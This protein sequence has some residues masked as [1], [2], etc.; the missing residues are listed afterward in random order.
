MAN[1]RPTEVQRADA[2]RNRA[3]ILEV[4]YQAFTENPN[5]SL[6]SIAK[7]ANIGPGTLY[8]HFPNREALLLAVNKSEID[9]LAEK[10]ERSLEEQEPLDAFRE[11][12]RRSAALIRVKH[13]LGEALSAAAHQSMTE[14]SYGPVISAINRLLTA[15]AENGDLRPGADP[16]DVLLLLGALWRVPAGDV[17]LRQADRILELIIDAL[18]P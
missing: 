16:S 2:L 5:A 14:T 18:R 8:R 12:A 15:A 4:A 13:G 11:W 3:H 10:V 6:N 1:S 17:G 7:R 9:S